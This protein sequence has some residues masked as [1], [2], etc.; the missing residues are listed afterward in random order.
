MSKR[1]KRIPPGKKAMHLYYD[2]LEDV[3][4]DLDNK[5]LG[6]LLR[7]LVMYDL[8]GEDKPPK[9]KGI[10]PYYKQGIKQL[11]RDLEKYREKSAKNTANIKKRWES[12]TI[13]ERIEEA[14]ELCKKDKSYKNKQKKASPYF[15]DL[16]VNGENN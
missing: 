10:K 4:E 5:S 11:D 2:F 12:L 1:E 3:I 16:T 6:E 7:A 8:Y 13:E 9:D 14:R 15:D